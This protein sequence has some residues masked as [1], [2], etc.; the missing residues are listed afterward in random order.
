VTTATSSEDQ[1]RQDAADYIK[2][3]FELSGMTQ[4]EFAR[5]LSIRQPELSELMAG[6]QAGRFSIQKINDVLGQLGA[7]IAMRFEQLGT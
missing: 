5:M 3:R 7:R 2:L 1:A 6:A 4:S